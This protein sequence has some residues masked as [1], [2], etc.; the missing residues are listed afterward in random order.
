[1]ANLMQAALGFLDG[2]AT[3]E[4]RIDAALAE[5]KAALAELYPRH[6]LTG[7]ASLRVS[8]GAVVAGAYPEE[9]YEARLHFHADNLAALVAKGGT[10]V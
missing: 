8:T 1:M 2:R 4:A 6:F 7:H 3:P 10:H 5:I 9:G